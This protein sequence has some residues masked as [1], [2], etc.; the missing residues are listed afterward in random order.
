MP[1]RA[2]STST[3]SLSTDDASD[4]SSGSAAM[5]PTADVDGMAGRSGAGNNR[6]DMSSCRMTAV[7]IVSASV[8][9]SVDAVDPMSTSGPM[10]S[11]PVASFDATDG[12]NSKI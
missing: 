7:A 2:A 1:L 11:G 10:P 5:L 3:P 12:Q 4:R 8:L 6:P 9:S